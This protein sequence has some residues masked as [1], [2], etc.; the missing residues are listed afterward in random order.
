MKNLFPVHELDPL[1]DLGEY[2]YCATGVVSLLTVQEI[3]QS[4]FFTQLH[5]HKDSISKHSI[6]PI[7]NDVRVS[8]DLQSL[9]LFDILCFIVG[10][11]DCN[12]LQSLMGT[13]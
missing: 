7:F 2:V 1:Q 6:I 5:N 13:D 10:L 8:Q 11:F 3:V 12:R 9:N 4:S